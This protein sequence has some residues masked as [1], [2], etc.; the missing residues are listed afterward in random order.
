MEEEGAQ[1]VFP[2]ELILTRRAEKVREVLNLI[3]YLVTFLFHL[4][5]IGKKPAITWCG[6]YVASDRPSEG[7]FATSGPWC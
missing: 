7:R 4:D 6:W 2:S 1:I 5:E 3:I